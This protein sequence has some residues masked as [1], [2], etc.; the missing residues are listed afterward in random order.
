[1]ENNIDNKNKQE[2]K[3]QEDLEDELCNHCT[4]WEIR[5]MSHFGTSCEGAKCDEA[6]ET[7]LLEMEEDA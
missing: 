2:I 6:Y 7:Y 3:K 1:M 4:L 5:H